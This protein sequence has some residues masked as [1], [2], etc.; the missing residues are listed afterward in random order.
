MPRKFE[1]SARSKLV[2]VAASL[3]FEKRHQ[4]RPCDRVMT[5]EGEPPLGGAFVGGE[6]GVRFSLFVG[7]RHLTKPLVRTDDSRLFSRDLLLI[8]CW[9]L[10]HTG[11]R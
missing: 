4:A 3:V 5:G 6:F 9:W 11:G 8:V 2:Q 10:P 1:D 7:H